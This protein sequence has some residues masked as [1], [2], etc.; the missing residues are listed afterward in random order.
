MESIDSVSSRERYYLV[1]SCV[2]ST[3]V[4]AVIWIFG[5]ASLSDEKS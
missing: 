3:A 5:N 2:I 4:K 1:D